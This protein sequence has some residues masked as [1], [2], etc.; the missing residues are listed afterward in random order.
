MTPTQLDLSRTIVA[1]SSGLAPAR[2]AIVRLSGQSTRS[3]L[4]RLIC[5]LATDSTGRTEN[6]AATETKREFLNSRRASSACFDLDIGWD[7]RQLPARIYYWPDHRSFTGE[8]GAELH[9]LGAMPIV[10]SLTERIVSL[11]ARLAE[12]GEFTLRSF[13][14]GKLDLTQAEAV[15]GVIEA[16]SPQQLAE[17]LEQLAGN[18]SIPVRQLRDQLVELVAHLEAGL[19][20]VEEDIE[21]ITP[22]LLLASLESICRQLKL[23]SDRLQ[24]RGARSRSARVTLVGL[25]NAGKSSLFNALLGMDRVIVSPQAGT[26]RDA[27][28]ETLTVGDLPVELIDTA[29]LEELQESSPRGLAQSVLQARLQQSDAIVFCVDASDPP[30]TQWIEDQEERLRKI[31]PSVLRVGTKADLALQPTTKGWGGLVSANQPETID[32][33][34]SELRQRLAESTQHLRSTAMHETAVRCRGSIELAQA[35]IERAMALISEAEGEEL[36]AVELRTA[37]DDLSAVIGEVHSD[38][39]LGEIFGRFCIG[40]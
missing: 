15:L 7:Q 29:G 8:P 24:S 14:A 22:P 13:L 5:P 36:V 27:V 26:T 38:D 4:D 3:I 1:M 10:E 2:R 18:L 9:V 28:V 20:F 23:I 32:W 40:K 17:S 33:L 30:T 21:F 35:A 31:V 37:L 39:I 25:P 12:R 19:D 6:V 16:D 34:R 11:G